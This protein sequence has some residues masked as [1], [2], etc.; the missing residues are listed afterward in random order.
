M[1]YKTKKP[2]QGKPEEALDIQQKEMGNTLTRSASDRGLA[3][4]SLFSSCVTKSI[5]G[6]GSMKAV[7]DMSTPKQEKSH[8][9]GICYTL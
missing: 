9:H 1:N 3:V 6:S 5:T 4:T 8:E 7:D 2:G